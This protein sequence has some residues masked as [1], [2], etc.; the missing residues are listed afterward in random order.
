LD[1][2]AGLNAAW[3][4]HDLR[5]TVR[6]GL[7]GLGAAPHVGEAILN[8]LPAKL[9]RTYDKNKYEPEKRQALDLWADHVLALVE[10]R[11]SK[12]TPLKR[13]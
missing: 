4:L 7:G 10:G 2:A 6:T 8:H 13:A 11:R 3:T 5:R 1:E 9:I 12:V